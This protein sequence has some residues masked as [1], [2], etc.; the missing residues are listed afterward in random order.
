MSSHKN[1]EKLTLY[2]IL[3]HIYESINDSRIQPEWNGIKVYIFSYY[4]HV[5]INIIKTSDKYIVRS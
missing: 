2:T 4:T 3:F 5:F 1:E